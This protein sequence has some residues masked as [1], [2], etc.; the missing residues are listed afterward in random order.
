MAPIEI[1]GIG[2]AL[3]ALV[4]FVGNEYGKLKAEYFWYDALNFLSA[5]GLFVYA[6]DQ[7]VVPFMLTNSVWAFVSGIDVLRHLL[8]ARGL[9]KRGK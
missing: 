6:Y 7:W 5:F 4:A 9:K 1:L 3:L 8:K 2:S